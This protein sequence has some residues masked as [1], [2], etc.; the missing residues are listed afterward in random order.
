MAGT[1]SAKNDLPFIGEV[2]LAVVGALSAFPARLAVE[3]L[4]VFL[5]LGVRCSWAVPFS[6]WSPKLCLLVA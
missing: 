6:F 2:A 5:L 4:Q 3:G 1:L